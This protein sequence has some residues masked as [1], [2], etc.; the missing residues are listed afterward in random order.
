MS[1]VTA[2]AIKAKH[3]FPRTVFIV[4]RH[5]G[6]V[7]KTRIAPELRLEREEGKPATVVPLRDVRPAFDGPNPQRVADVPPGA[8]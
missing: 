5:K 1:K 6:K 7:I 4:V 2:E 8:A 3:T